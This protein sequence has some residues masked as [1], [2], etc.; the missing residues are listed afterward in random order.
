MDQ[1]SE[2]KMRAFKPADLSAV[3]ELIHATIEASYA[4]VYPPRAVAFFREFHSPSAI[5]QRHVTGSIVQVESEGRTVG[6]GS[7]VGAEITGVFVDP[8]FQ[9]RGIGGRI[10]DELEREARA[11]GCDSIRLSVSLPSRRFYERRGYSVV[12]ECS[13]DVGE[14]Q[15]LDYWEAQ[16]P[17][18]GES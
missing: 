5:L 6:T 2:L 10:M 3:S 7:I 12:E 17:L 18:G 9:G 4:G 15:R 1:E 16:K 14:G 8:A 11:H 13:I